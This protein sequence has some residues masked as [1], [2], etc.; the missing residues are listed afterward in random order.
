MIERVPLFTNGSSCHS[1][2]LIIS[3][4]A[5]EREKLSREVFAF[6]V[7]MKQEHSHRIML[8]L[9]IYKNGQG[10]HLTKQD[11]I[12]CMYMERAPDSGIYIYQEKG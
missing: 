3:V 12:D 10:S 2:I 9:P 8:Q 1:F 4:K 7:N 11:T 6:T 5:M